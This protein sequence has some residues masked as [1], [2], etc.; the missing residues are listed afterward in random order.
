MAGKS[1]IKTGYYTWAK[2]K[3]VYLKTGATTWTAVRKAYLKT[4][5]ATWKK[6]FDTSS[7][8]PFI[9][10]NDYPKIRLN[11]Y[12]STSTSGVQPPV[13][14][15]P[16]Q[17]IGPRSGGTKGTSTPSPTTGLA[18][19]DGLGSFLWGYDGDW[20]PET[21][22]TFTYDW[23]WANTASADDATAS[24]TPATSSGADDKISNVNANLGWLV[25]NEPNGVWLYFRVNASNASGVAR[26]VST[27]VRLIRQEP[28]ASTW[29]MVSAASSSLNTP[30]FISTSISNLWYDA[31]HF[32]E[33]KVEWFSESSNTNPALNSTTLV[34]TETLASFASNRTEI[35][36]TAITQQPSY[37]P[38][39]VNSLGYSDADKYI[40][41]K[42]TL[43][44]SYTKYNNDPQI[45]FTSTSVPVGQVRTIT[46][47]WNDYIYVS[48][49]G[50]I[51]LAGSTGNTGLN[52]TG[53]QGHVVSFLNKDLKQI[54]LKYKATA[55]EYIV[56]WSGKIYDVASNTVTYR[57]QAIFYPGQNY[58]DFHVITNG[59]GTSG[60]AY[61]YNGAQQVPWGASKPTGSAYRIYLTSGVAF[62]SITYSPVSTTTG[63][64]SVTTQDQ[65]DDGA[66]TLQLIQGVSKPTIISQPSW[67]LLSGNANR[68]GAVYRLYVGSWS[69]SPTSY[70]MHLYRNDQGGYDTSGFPITLNSSQTYYDWTAT[71]SSVSLSLS[72][73][74]TNSAGTSDISTATTSIG[75]FT[76][77]LA[78]PTPTSVTWDGTSFKIYSSGGDGPYYQMWYSTGTSQPDSAI[79]GYDYSEVAPSPITYT[80]SFSPSTGSTYNF[81]LR[82]ATSLTAASYNVNMG[83]YSQ[84]YVS[85]TIPGPSA[86]SMN[87]Y[88]STVTPNGPNSITITQSSNTLNFD[89]PDEAAATGGWYSSISGG[90]QGARNNIRT[91]SYDFWSV[92]ANTYYS[93]QVYAINTSK[94]VTMDWSG[95]TGANSWTLYYD[96]NG[97]TTQT[98]NTTLTSFTIS[99]TGAVRVLGIRAFANSNYTGA[100]RDGSYNSSLSITPTNK[101][102]SITYWSTTYVPVTTYGA[103]D[104]VNGTTYGS[105]SDN[106]SGQQYRQCRTATTTYKRIIYIDGTNSGTYDTSGCTSTTTAQDCTSYSYTN[107]KCGYTLTCTASCGT[108]SAYGAYGP[109]TA[110]GACYSTGAAAQKDRS[111]ERCRTR[112]CIATD[113]S[114]YVQTSCE[115]QVQSTACTVTRWICNSFDYSNSTSANY[116][117][118][119]TP[120]GGDCNARFN[121]AGTRSS[122]AFS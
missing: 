14:A 5:S 70:E 36:G 49:N 3:K 57:Y 113:C 48:T 67:Q 26:A 51:G 39:N 73:Y 98:L 118:C 111:R 81:W 93:G 8:R 59:G 12:R 55:T 117:W 91:V 116:Q 79:N 7:N 22:V 65:V 61:L 80:P 4:G 96:I 77:N 53:T 46:P 100:Y 54:S 52:D 40:I 83:Q 95:G 6:V 34:K 74:A 58:V 75:P 56:D 42:L 21:G 29:S 69:N 44:N 72:V 106:C 37:T 47:Q 35:D 10:N 17:F 2:I 104:V 15:P 32:Y 20:E 60:N 41:A 28:S 9:E 43:I 102:S 110:Y 112:T 11:T 27:P 82:S 13:A 115:T 64:T 120:G 103:C 66:T 84:N 108:Y 1:Y 38:V 76:A 99:T 33:S 19:G 31:P 121:S 23:F 71:S 85:V 87:I 24:Y 68:I 90:T 107:G 105:Y 16:V 88:D 50:Y 92:T 45:Y 89:W 78:A 94:Q 86:F 62:Q 18:G 30:K 109:Y 122:C 101:N 97:G 63:F 114:S 25:N 119:L